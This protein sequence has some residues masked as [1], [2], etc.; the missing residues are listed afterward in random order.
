M[1]PAPSGAADVSPERKP[2]VRDDHTTFEP[3]KGDE[4]DSR[5][6]VTEEQSNGPRGLMRGGIHAPAIGRCHTNTGACSEPGCAGS[7]DIHGPGVEAAIQLCA[8]LD[9]LPAEVW[10][11]AVAAADTG[12]G[13]ELSA[14]VAAAIG[15]MTDAIREDVRDWLTRGRC[16][17]A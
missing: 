14:P 8:G 5:E 17:G 15:A 1:N 9:T 16:E 12:Y 7:Y 13:E 10:V 2:W 4:A 3:R 6:D 11:Y